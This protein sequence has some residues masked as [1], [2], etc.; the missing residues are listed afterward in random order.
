MASYYHRR[1]RNLLKAMKGAGAK[2][3]GYKSGKN[4]VTITA[5]GYKAVVEYTPSGIVTSVKTTNHNPKTE[6]LTRELKKYEGNNVNPILAAIS[7][8]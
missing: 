6:R 1:V 8:L 2:P 7:Q 3:Q 4:E 5:G